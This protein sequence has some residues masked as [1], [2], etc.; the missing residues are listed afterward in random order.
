[1]LL[2]PSGLFNGQE[3]SGNV[4]IAPS[5]VRVQLGRLNLGARQRQTSDAAVFV[6]TTQN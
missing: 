2:S 3:V 6:A 1:V 5:H 4:P